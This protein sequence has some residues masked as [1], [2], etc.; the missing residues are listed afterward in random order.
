MKTLL[1][2]IGGCSIV[3]VLVIFSAHCLGE[4]AIWLKNRRK[5]KFYHVERLAAMEVGKSI[6]RDSYWFSDNPEH[7]RLLE[8]L[9]RDIQDNGRFRADAVRHEFRGNS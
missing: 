2:I 9:G 8:I 4:L 6:R 7:V 3:F 1:M 5:K